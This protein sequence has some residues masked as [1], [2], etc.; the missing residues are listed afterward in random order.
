[1]ASAICAPTFLSSPVSSTKAVIHTTSSLASHSKTPKLHLPKAVPQ[2]D[3]GLFS[4]WSGLKHL[5]I[6]FTPKSFNSGS[7]S[8]LGSWLFHLLDIHYSFSCLVC[9]IYLECDSL[10]YFFHYFFLEMR[11]VQRGSGGVKVWWFMHLFLVL[12]LLRLWSLGWWLCWFLVPK[13]LPRW[14]VGFTFSLLNIWV[15]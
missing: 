6:S 11:A 4:P 12:E 2:L 14:V 10:L 8:H 5:G 1:M 15:S 7:S 3:P 9:W 13:V